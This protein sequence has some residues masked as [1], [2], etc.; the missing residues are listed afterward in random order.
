MK[1]LIC[2]QIVDKDHPILGFFHRWIEEFA[3]NCEEVHVICLQKGQYS[4]PANVYVYSLGKEEGNSKLVQLYN[5]Y[6]YIWRLR[7]KYDSVFVHMNQIYVILGG[8]L[9]RA[10]GKRVGLWYA[11]GAVSKSLFFAEK[12]ADSI[13]TSTQEGFRL[14]SKKVH[15]VGQGIDMLQFT[16]SEN[17][18]DSEFI[19]IVYA[20]RISPVKQC[21]VLIK[22]ARLL[23]DKKIKCSV[24]LIGDASSSEAQQYLSQL[25]LLIRELNLESIVKFAGA[26]K[27][28]EIINFLREADIFVNPSNTGSLDKTGIE[29]LA[30][31]VPVITCNESYAGLYG[32]HIS[33]LMF[34]TGDSKELSEQITK[35]HT[36][37]QRKSI[38]RE[39]STKVQ[40]EYD[41]VN[42]ISKVLQAI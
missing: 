10:L 17:K 37:T 19:R 6:R 5:F 8:F 40:N 21:E 2:T 42:F 3:K 1:L 30:T 16:Y 23:A 14:K 25:K 41:I 29:A 12:I 32:Q 24:I 11:H 20:G 31:G 28:S 34:S 15:V 36:S 33:S 38:I 26:V 18:Y 4:L 9:W 13:I 35:L 27:N 7:K 22:A 39:L